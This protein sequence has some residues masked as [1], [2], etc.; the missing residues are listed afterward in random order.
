[1]GYAEAFA[2]G[3]TGGGAAGKAGGKVEAK[4]GEKVE[5]GA[6]GK[7]GGRAEG[8]AARVELLAYGTSADAADPY[9]EEVPDSFVGYAALAWYPV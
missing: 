7:A 5:G 4:A 3:K 1:M 8:R 6:A 2:K 9:G